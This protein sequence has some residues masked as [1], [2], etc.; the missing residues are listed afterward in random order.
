MASGEPMSMN[1]TITNNYSKVS[2]PTPLGEYAATVNDASGVIPLTF[3][4]TINIPFHMTPNIQKNGNIITL[5]VKPVHSP[6]PP[7][8]YAAVFPKQFNIDVLFDASFVP[9]DYA[10]PGDYGS[11]NVPIANGV[12]NANQVGA[13]VDSSQNN[14]GYIKKDVYVSN[15]FFIT[16]NRPIDISAVVFSWAMGDLS[17]QKLPR[18]F[19]GRAL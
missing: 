5:T 11:N 1:V 2:D 3:G 9:F 4:N 16:V 7:L 8:H 6:K 18:Q 14:C 15:H 12:L 19:V 10:S 17:G 13:I